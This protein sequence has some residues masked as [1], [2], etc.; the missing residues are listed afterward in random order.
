[1]TGIVA[2]LLTSPLFPRRQMLAGAIILLLPL[3]AWVL[4]GLL[5]NPE[6]PGQPY[7]VR[8]KEAAVWSRAGAAVVS[9]HNGAVTPGALADFMQA[10]KRD[11][12]DP[13]AWFYIGLAEAQAGNYKKAVGYW[14]GLLAQSPRDA[15]WTIM[16]KKYIAAYA[17]KGGFSPSSAVAAAPAIKKP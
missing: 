17:R 1:M 13:R 11:A 7:V 4:Y 10:L 6:L 12:K 16:T 2:A 15:P 3:L 14:N 9:A 8:L 5:G